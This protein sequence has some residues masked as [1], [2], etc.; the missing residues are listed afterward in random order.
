MAVTLTGLM[1]GLTQLSGGHRDILVRDLG[2]QSSVTGA[3]GRGISNL[4]PMD[5]LTLRSKSRLHTARDRFQ[6]R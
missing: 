6:E 4:G 5:K 2:Y 3:C 1:T